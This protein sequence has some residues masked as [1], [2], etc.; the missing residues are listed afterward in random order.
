MKR[1]AG[2]IGDYLCVDLY[3]R[4]AQIQIFTIRRRRQ[5]TNKEYPEFELPWS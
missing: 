2:G 3:L 5:N 4:F 1:E